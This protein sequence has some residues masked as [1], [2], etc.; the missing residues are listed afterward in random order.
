MDSANPYEIDGQG[1][2][3]ITDEYAVLYRPFHAEQDNSWKS[4]DRNYSDKTEKTFNKNWGR[5][6]FH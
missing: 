3:S 2:K 4:D 5:G 6:T 1:S